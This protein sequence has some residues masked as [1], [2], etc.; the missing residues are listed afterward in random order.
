[1]FRRC[2]RPIDARIEWRCRA[3]RLCQIPLENIEKVSE[4]RKILNALKKQPFFTPQKVQKRPQ[5]IV[6]VNLKKQCLMHYYLK[7]T[8]PGFS[9]GSRRSDNII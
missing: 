8:D 9:T 6:Q 2:S 1:M 5:I 3:R 4:I 7:F